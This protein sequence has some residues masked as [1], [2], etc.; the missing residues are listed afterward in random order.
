MADHLKPSVSSNYSLFVNEMSARFNDLAMG[1]N[2]AAVIA[3]GTTLNATG[4]PVNSIRW[5][6][7]TD[8]LKWQRLTAT[9]WEDLAATYAISISGNAAT[10]TNGVYTNAS[11]ANPAW[12]TGLAGTKITGDIGGNSGT[13]TR[14]ATPRNING[15]AFDGSAAISINLNNSVTFNT[16]GSGATSGSA[17][18]GGSALTISYNTI[19]APSTT[20]AGASGT[21]AISVTGSATSATTTTNIAISNDT[22]NGA[23]VYPVWVTGTSSGTGLKISSTKVSFI[24]ST[25]DLRA[26][27]F[28]TSNFALTGIAG[29]GGLFNGTGDGASSTIA[30]V[31]LKSWYG[32]GFA[33]SISGQDVPQGEN[34][35][36]I[37]V[38]TGSIG[39]RGDIY[40]SASIYANSD[41]TLKTNW[42]SL[43]ENFVSQLAQIKSGVYDRLDRVETQVGVGA[44]S[45]QKLLPNAVTVDSNG[46]LSVAYGNAALVS[47]IELAREIEL[48]KQE[49]KL[50][51]GG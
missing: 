24:P 43:P 22:T 48:L 50:L 40:T 41:E 11:Y 12:I 46:K 33:P 14:L 1:L 16:S 44:Q 3:P 18:N 38:R 51:K 31:Q 17:F 47:A 20:G 25:G 6:G 15:V 9:G 19:G 13:A 49:I 45:L 29:G 39:A 8:A 35:V 4:L 42:Q 30:N 36:W 23:T 2:P 37:D 27:T 21:W 34:A 10:V 5:N 32:I 26:D 28:T 7:N